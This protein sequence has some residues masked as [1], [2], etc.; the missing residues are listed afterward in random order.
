MAFVAGFMLL[1]RCQVQVVTVTESIY[2][3]ADQ[4]IRSDM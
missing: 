2:M 4:I 1:V 3:Y